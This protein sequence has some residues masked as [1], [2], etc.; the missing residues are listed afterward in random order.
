MIS[1][2]FVLISW[3]TFCIAFA[4]IFLSLPRIFQAIAT[5]SRVELL[6]DIMLTFLVLVVPVVMV[7][8]LIFWFSNC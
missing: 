4:F 6:E 8:G 1:F 2:E 7:V 3:F 5:K